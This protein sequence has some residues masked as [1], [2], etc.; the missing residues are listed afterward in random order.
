MVKE[1]TLSRKRL[2]LRESL[3]TAAQRT[4]SEH[5]YRALRARDLAAEVGCA[6]G[7]IYNVF[8]DM[9]ALI[10]V[11]KSRTLD[12]LQA[13]IINGLGPDETRTP[14]DGEARLLAATRIYLDFA[15]RNR[16][17]WLSAFEHS[18]P[19]T[20]VLRAY[21]L[22]LDAIF[23]NVDGP[24]MAIL[25]GMEERPR[26]LLARALFSAVHGVVAL[27]LDQKLGGISEEEL[28]WQARVVLSAALA[29]LRRGAT[30]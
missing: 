25:P 3:I 10:L 2:D 23:A 13:D 1:M 11:I 24:L 6:V 27:G 29:G 15:R 26:K 21:M 28:H 18:S 9:D 5:G 12:E 4:V 16:E 14:E 17:L 20:P 8:P 7:A 22:R 19:D 30:A